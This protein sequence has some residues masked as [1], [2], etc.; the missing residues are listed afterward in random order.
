MKI[1]LITHNPISTY[2]NMGKTFLS[3]FSE[4]DEAELCQFYIHTSNPDVKICQ[5]YYR[6]TDSEALKSLYTACNLGGE[7]YFQSAGELPEITA[8]VI[9]NKDSAI[10]RLA[11]DAVWK[12]SKWYSPELI[13]WLDREKPTHIF[14]APGY[15]KFI[16]DIAI[17][18]AEDLQLPIVAYI[19]DD[20]YF[21]KTPTSILEKIQLLLLKKKMDALMKKTCCLVTICDEIKN[22]YSEFFNVPG[23]TIMTGASVRKLKDIDIERSNQIISYFGNIGWGKRY[24]SLC[25]VGRV[26]EQINRQK[27][28]FYTLKVYTD[29]RNETILRALSSVSTIRLCAFVTGDAFVEAMSEADLLLHVEAFDEKSVDIVKYSVSTK[30]ADSLASGIPL[31]AYCPENISSMKHLIHNNCALT[32]TSQEE[33]KSILEDTLLHPV[34]LV[35]IAE[36]A[37]QTAAK[38]HDKKTNSRRLKAILEEAAGNTH[39]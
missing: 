34:S 15:A 33:L 14:I 35:E 32:A 38:C 10:K 24:L 2:N 36:R 18:I 28:T 31:L 25:E 1:L 23:V 6:I 39:E 8:P 13:A 37:Q 17:K 20:Y 29:E 4:F 19:C 26:L 27:G 12:L 22:R 5:S 21:V 3:L 11:R 30:I 7:V 9:K 16:Y